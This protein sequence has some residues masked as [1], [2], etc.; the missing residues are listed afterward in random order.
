LY[1][2]NDLHDLVCPVPHLFLHPLFLFDIHIESYRI[3]KGISKTSSHL[4][5]SSVP[6][7]LC[8]CCKTIS[9]RTSAGKHYMYTSIAKEILKFA[10]FTPR[11][12]VFQVL[13]WKQNVQNVCAM[14]Q[15]CKK[16]FPSHWYL[17]DCYSKLHNFD[18]MAD[19]LTRWFLSDKSCPTI[20]LKLSLND[21]YQ[22]RFWKIVLKR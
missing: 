4:Q 7:F 16:W 1:A 5:N 6:N 8:T 17:S 20:F 19:V 15:C 10:Q 22:A 2:E 12:T 21:P 18:N 11:R 9:I 14:A 13:S 3:E